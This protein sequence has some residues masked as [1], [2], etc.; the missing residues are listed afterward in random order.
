MG[1]EKPQPRGTRDVIEV[2]VRGQSEGTVEDEFERPV[3]VTVGDV[4]GDCADEVAAGN[5]GS[6]GAQVQV[7]RAAGIETVEFCARNRSS[8]RGW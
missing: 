4:V 2:V 7:R 8:S 3:P 5:E 6:R 1:R